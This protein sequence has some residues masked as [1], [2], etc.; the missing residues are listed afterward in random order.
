M[1]VKPHVQWRFVF[2]LIA[3]TSKQR[4]ILDFRGPILLEP[5]T[6]CV[7]DYLE[8]RDGQFGF[9]P[10][11]GRFCTDNRMLRPITSTGQWLWLHFH[12]DFSIEKSGFQAVFYYDLIPADVTIESI[13]TVS[14]GGLFKADNVSQLMQTQVQ[15]VDKPGFQ[16]INRLREIILDFR[17]SEPDMALLFH[18]SFIKFPLND[19]NCQYNLIEIYDQFFLSDRTEAVPGEKVRSLKKLRSR[20]LLPRVVRACNQ[21]QLD[22]VFHTLGRGIVRIL[23]SSPQMLQD[24]E[25][26]VIPTDMPED[27]VLKQNISAYLPEMTLAFTALSKAPCKPGWTPCMTREDLK[28]FHEKLNASGISLV[29][30]LLQRSVSS[31]SQ[32]R[33]PVYTVEQLNGLVLDSI[34][35]VAT[36]LECDNNTNCP[37]EEDEDGCPRPTG[38]L[39]NLF[40]HYDRLGKHPLAI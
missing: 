17:T 5:S 23:S 18:L 22:P 31:S 29:D 16:M 19:P 8:I 10:M 32:I 27:P 30:V 35:C 6:G 2:S 37:N 3:P 7:N 11:I 38:K 9:S 12:T 40:D 15:N 20:R 13:I 4:I 1:I 34:Y 28:F 14:T 36:S 39:D 26:G 21:P 24:M 33:R 25:E